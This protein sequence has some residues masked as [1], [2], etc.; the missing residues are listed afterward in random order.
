MKLTG[1]SVDAIGFDQ[2]F[3][4]RKHSIRLLELLKK[5]KKGVVIE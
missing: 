5:G 2:N 3:K 4:V 1:V